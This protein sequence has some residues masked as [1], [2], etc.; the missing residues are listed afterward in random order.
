MTKETQIELAQEIVKQAML[1]K[2]EGVAHV[3]VNYSGHVDCIDVWAHPFDQN[4]TDYKNNPYAYLFNYGHIDLND[5]KTLTQA[6]N[7]INKL[8]SEKK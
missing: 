6:L 5:T 7:D 1:A 4:Y 8:W 3:F 2:Q